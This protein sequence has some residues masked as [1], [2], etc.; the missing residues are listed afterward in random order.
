MEKKKKRKRKKSTFLQ[1]EWSSLVY[2]DEWNWILSDA[3][4]YTNRDLGKFY[5]FSKL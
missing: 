2:G 5:N 1:S 4:I 3:T